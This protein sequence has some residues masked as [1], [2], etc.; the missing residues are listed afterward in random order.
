MQCQNQNPTQL[1][2]PV[3]A[4]IH[5]LWHFF[6]SG[7]LWD[8]CCS[9]WNPIVH[10]AAFSGPVAAISLRGQR[11]LDSICS[12]W[13]RSGHKVTLRK[14]T[15]SFFCTSTG[16]S[17]EEWSPCVIHPPTSLRHFFG[18]SVVEDRQRWQNRRIFFLYESSRME[19]L[20]W[21]YIHKNANH[22]NTIKTWTNSW[23]WGV[24]LTTPPVKSTPVTE[25]QT[26]RNH[27]LSL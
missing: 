2:T 11:P 23:G 3:V 15:N 16:P 13:D 25:T 19:T 24:G 27:I 14:S 21:C 10:S 9:E 18:V 12:P 4:V 8:S 7:M 6:Q 22:S 1:S 5:M 20:T 26:S 17:C